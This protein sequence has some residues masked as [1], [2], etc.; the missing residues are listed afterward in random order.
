MNAGDLL[1]DGAETGNEPEAPEVATQAAAPEPV[2]VPPELASIKGVLD[3]TSQAL[4]GARS[5]PPL[6]RCARYSTHNARCRNGREEAINS[7]PATSALTLTQFGRQRLA[8]HND[9]VSTA[10]CAANNGT[11]PFDPA[12]TGRAGETGGDSTDNLPVRGRSKHVHF[13]CGP[14]DDGR[15]DDQWTGRRFSHRL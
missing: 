9:Q 4:R 1:R 2:A 14:E 10:T 3:E 8:D 13:P 12:A 6:M 5:I 7:L 11:L 15:A